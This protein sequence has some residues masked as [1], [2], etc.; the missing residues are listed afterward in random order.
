MSSKGQI[1]VFKDAVAIITGGASG[2]GRS[3]AY[4]LA[5][6]GCSVI[7]ADLQAGPAEEVVS[8]IRKQGGN[9]SAAELNVTDFA[10]VNDLVESTMKEY[11]RL[12][13]FFNNAGI[14]FMG[15]VDNYSID[16]WNYTVDINLRGVIN[17]VQAVY[18]VMSEQGFGHIVNTASM[19]G[20]IPTAGS[21]SY[22]A[23]KHAVVGL[24]KALL[25]EAVG[26]NLRVSV[27]CPG[28]IR[29][30]IMNGGKYG[31]DIQNLTKR[32]QENFLCSLEK[33]KPMDPDLF[34]KRAIDSVAKNR[35]LIILPKWN[36]LFWLM[37]RLSPTLGLRFSQLGYQNIKKTINN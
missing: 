27:F 7:I 37:D 25:T 15:D 13:Y 33:I 10:A 31:R 21:I 26:K 36:R 24:S 19:A 16:D 28:I 34:A 6:R 1:R 14:M 9:A 5:S 22:A 2:I 29:T 12:D 17:G 18:R 4:E 32:Q 11:G 23:T 3:L 35:F 30:P 8:Q 20:L